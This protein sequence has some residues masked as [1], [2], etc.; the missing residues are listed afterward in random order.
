MS[1]A[2]AH[3]TCRCPSSPFRYSSDSDPVAVLV[4]S[5]GF[6]LKE[7]KPDYASLVLVFAVLPPQEVYRPL[8]K[9]GLRSRDLQCFPGPS[10]R[11]ECTCVLQTPATS[12]S[13]AKASPCGVI[14]MFNYNAVVSISNTAAQS[15]QAQTRS[16]QSQPD[17]MFT[18]SLSKEVAYKYSLNAIVDGGP[19]PSD[20]FA[21]VMKGGGVLFIESEQQR[22]RLAA[23]AGGA[24][25]LAVDIFN[26]TQP[27]NFD[28]PTQL[29]Y[30]SV[31]WSRLQWSPTGLQIGGTA[32]GNSLLSCCSLHVGLTA[33]CFRSV[34]AASL[35][36][37]FTRC[38]RV[39]NQAVLL[40]GSRAP[41]FLNSLNL[42]CAAFL[43]F[44][45]L[46]PSTFI[47]Q[48]AQCRKIPASAF[49][50]IALN[51]CKFRH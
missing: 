9:N 31:A 17:A 32:S 28:S 48:R 25:P 12:L 10:I 33:G 7:A 5:S 41:V 50:I 11:L 27:Q 18:T 20:W 46:C 1:T 6:A 29:L 21:S 39:A 22:W 43:L 13:A 42:G 36:V 19:H 8:K 40:G 4:H 23:A 3:A 30:P 34:I 16:S 51:I 14:R 15:K 38:C 37:K 49:C 35:C 45:R 2:P 47:P 26:C 44:A 24:A